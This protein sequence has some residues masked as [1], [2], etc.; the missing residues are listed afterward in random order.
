MTQSPPN[1]AAAA[2]GALE[3]IQLRTSDPVATAEWYRDVLGATVQMTSPFWSRVRLGNVDI[4]I[5]EGTPPA[6][7]G[8]E[9]GFRVLDIAAVRATL[10]ARDVEIT[11]PFHDIPGGVKLGF[12]DIAGNGLAVYQYG[13]STADLEAGPAP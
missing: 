3:L 10:E 13:I 8:W 2:I 4:G 6:E 9:P 5:H 1:T 11:Q 7:S 12:R